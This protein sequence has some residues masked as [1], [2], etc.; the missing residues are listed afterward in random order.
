MKTNKEKNMFSRCKASA[1]VVILLTLIAACGKVDPS[2]TPTAPLVLPTSSPTQIP[3]SPTDTSGAEVQSSPVLTSLEGAY[4]GQNPPGK[5]PRVFAPGTIS[6]NANFEHSAA[7]FSPDNREVFWT[8]NVNW[9]TDERVVGSQ[10]LYN[11]KMVDGKWTSPQIAPFA[12][13]INVPIQRPVFSPEG[14]KLYIELF[15]LDDSDIFVVER[16]GEGWSEPVPVSPLINS[17]AI[18]RLHC[19]TADGS[20]YFSRDPFTEREK[21]FV[22]RLVNGAFTEPEQLG[23][24]YDSDDYEVAILIAP[25]EEYMLIEQMNTQH[26]SSALTVS[27]KR[28]DGTWSD[29]IKAPYECG[30]FLALSPDGE[31]LFFLGEGIYWVS[32]SFIDDLKPQNLAANPPPSQ[33]PTLAPT[34]TPTLTTEMDTLPGDTCVSAGLPERAC[35][36]VFTNDAWTPVV[37]EFNGVS[38]VLVPAGCFNMG[39]DANLPEEQ[40]VHRICFERPFWIDRTETTVAQFAQFLNG[41]DEPVD[42]YDGWLDV[43]ANLAGDGDLPIQL[44]VKDGEWKPLRERDNQPIENVTWIGAHDYC[45]WRDARLPTEAEWEYA[46][47]GPDSLLYPWGNEYISANLLR[48]SS[49]QMPDVGSIPRGASW[50]GA[51]DMSG[52][53]YEWTSSLYRPYPYD[54]NDGR[55][56]SLEDDFGNRVFRGCPWYHSENN[57]HGMLRDNVSATARHDNKPDIAFWYFGFRCAR[58][59]NP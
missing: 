51:L 55:E 32:T 59:L 34:S 57:L 25:H 49:T 36:G 56:T 17:P 43:I 18:E 1:A 19:V 42:S 28:A 7:V 47:R 3:I 53:L 46:A 2:V 26:T 54:P 33:P 52:S 10:R 30:G 29:R 35:Q 11:M 24:S 27:Y 4:L 38:M 23:E 20:L 5:T 21:I 40:P 31:Y 50:V 45:A 15:D 58:S 48:S 12:E 22:S 9:Y 6:V 44:T 8:T 13:D 37:H 16:I 39:N 41:Q 14:N